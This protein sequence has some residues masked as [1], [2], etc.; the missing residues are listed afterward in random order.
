MS[1]LEGIIEAIEAESK[2]PSPSHNNLAR[3]VALGLKAISESLEPK[4]QHQED[5]KPMVDKAFEQTVNY[6]SQEE[7]K[8]KKR[9]KK[10]K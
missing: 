3:L 6:V 10:Q 5:P 7:P 4:E 1:I 9:L 8:L 2:Q